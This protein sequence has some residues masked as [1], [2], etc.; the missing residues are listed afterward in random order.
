MYKYKSTHM[1]LLQDGTIGIAQSKIKFDDDIKTNYFGD[2]LGFP[3]HMVLFLN[4]L[5]S[6]Q[7]IEKFS[8]TISF[9][10]Q[11]ISSKTL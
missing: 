2:I 4:L 9:R 10:K 8:H 1:E 3:R 5:N 11:F 7:R 6:P